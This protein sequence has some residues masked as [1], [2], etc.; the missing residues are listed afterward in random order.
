MDA[1]LLEGMGLHPKVIGSAELPD[2][3]IRIGNRATLIPNPGSMSYGIVMELS[4]EEAVALYS[5]QDVSD[6]RAETV[7]AILINDRSIQRSLCYNLPPDV[8]ESE[9]NADY[10]E[11]LSALVLKL[12]FSSVY[13][14]EISYRRDA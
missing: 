9:T 4:N 13:A 6:Y 5:K 2:F 14:N 10:A 1:N 3:Q 12:G 11:K 8:L 7:D